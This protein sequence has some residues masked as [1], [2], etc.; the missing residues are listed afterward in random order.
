MEFK[1]IEEGQYLCEVEDYNIKTSNKN[2]YT[3]LNLRLTTEIEGEKVSL[4]KSYTLDRGVNHQIKVLLE[5]IGGIKKKKAY[6]KKLYEFAFWATVE[7]DDY[8]KLVVTKL[9]V[10]EEL[11][12]E[13]SS[14]DVF[15]TGEEEEDAD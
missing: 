7:Y 11:E 5:S 4:R 15:D 2:G 6:Y 9:E 1:Y 3:Y 13:E 8:G 12:D 10:A 14:D